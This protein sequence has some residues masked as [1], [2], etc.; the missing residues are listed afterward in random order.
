[1]LVVKRF[2]LGSVLADILVEFLSILIKRESVFWFLY[3]AH[4]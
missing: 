3:A 1:M 4:L 2:V